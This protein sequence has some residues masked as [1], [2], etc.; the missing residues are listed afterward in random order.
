MQVTTPA[1]FNKLF[2]ATGG[3]LYGRSSHGWTASFQRPGART[4]IPG[5]YLAGGS[6][7]PGPGVPMA[8]LSGRS[9][10]ASLMADLGSISQS[11]KTAMRGGM[12]MR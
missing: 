2:P 3:A 5:L 6:T 10:A 12:S 1:D 9:A 8:A 7:H 11:P 4:R